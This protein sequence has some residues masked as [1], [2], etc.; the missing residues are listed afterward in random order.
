[1]SVDGADGDNEDA[2]AES[3]TVTV[4]RRDNGIEGIWIDGTPLGAIV[5]SHRER[6]E[7]LETENRQLREKLEQARADSKLAL[8]SMREEAG[9]E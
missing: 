5:H 4:E 6:I 9:N 1:M 2:E 3:A 8:N 7:A